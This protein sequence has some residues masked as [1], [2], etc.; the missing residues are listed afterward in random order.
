MLRR[1]SG[2]RPAPSSC[3]RRSAPRICAGVRVELAAAARRRSSPTAGPSASKARLKIGYVER[4]P[5]ASPAAPPSRVEADRAAAVRAA[6]DEDVAVGRLDDRH[7]A[8]AG[9]A[10]AD[11]AWRTPARRTAAAPRRTRAARSAGRPRGM[12]CSACGEQRVGRGLGR[13]RRRL[14]EV[15]RRRAG[16]ARQRAEVDREP[17]SS[18]LTPGVGRLAVAGDVGRQ[19]QELVGVAGLALED[20]RA[21]W[22]RSAAAA[23][24]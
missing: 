10:L 12:L 11:A 9:V 15:R 21:R 16:D 23:R 14:A 1:C 3:R 2:R 24:S 18:A 17:S 19:R 22:P 5:A 4:R 6:A 7:R 13:R 8:D 20:Q